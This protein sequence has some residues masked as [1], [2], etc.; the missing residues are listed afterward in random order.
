MSPELLYP[1]KFGLTE[2]RP[3]VKSDIYALGMVVYEVLSGRVPFAA[4][5]DPEVVSKVLDGKR[6]ERPR[7]DAGK[8]FT[9]DIWEVLECCWEQ[10]PKDRPSVQCVL[11]VLDGGLSTSRPPSDTDEE[12][13]TDTDDENTVVNKEKSE[14]STESRSCV[15]S[16]P[17]MFL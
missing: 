4:Y 17:S 9:D 10:Q 13:E 5:R 14:P 12:A 15:E 6:P 3:T 1:E 7:G 8:P 16:E 2:K 11:E